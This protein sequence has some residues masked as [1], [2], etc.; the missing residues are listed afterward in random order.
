MEQP[1]GIIDFARHY[2]VRYLIV[3]E[4]H[5]VRFRPQ[6]RK[7]IPDSPYPGSGWCTASATTGGAPSST[8]STRRPAPFHGRVPLLDLGESR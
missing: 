6:L 4:A 3:D 8:S 1:D 2:G 7:I 5:G